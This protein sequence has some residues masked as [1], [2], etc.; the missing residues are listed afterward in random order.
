MKKICFA[1]S[2]DR[3]LRPVASLTIPFNSTPIYSAIVHDP[4]DPLEGTPIHELAFVVHPDQQRFVIARADILEQRPSLRL[5]AG[6]GSHGQEGFL[7][8]EDH[9]RPVSR[10]TD[11]TTEVNK[12][13]DFLRRDV[14]GSTGPTST[15]TP[16]NPTR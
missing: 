12:L 8:S 1:I 4:P 5:R 9:A 11:H 7:E 13:L 6:R 16:P 15:G 2:R 3:V 10:H 14:G